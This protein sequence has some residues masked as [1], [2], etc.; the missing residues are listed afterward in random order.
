VNV[1]V[2][3]TDLEPSQFTVK[4]MNG[5]D[6]ETWLSPVVGRSSR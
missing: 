6:W 1:E 4:Q 5:G 2:K 3:A